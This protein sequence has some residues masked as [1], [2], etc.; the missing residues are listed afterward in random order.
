MVLQVALYQPDDQFVTQLARRYVPLNYPVQFPIL[1]VSEKTK[2]H[3][4]VHRMEKQATDCESSTSTHQSSNS[5]YMLT[6]L[7]MLLII[8]RI[9]PT[10][11][12]IRIK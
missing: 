7:F 8:F 9:V 4:T 12:I 10:L 3:T 5:E 2:T 6:S 11:L 1:I